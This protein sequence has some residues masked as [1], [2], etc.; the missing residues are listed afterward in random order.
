MHAVIDSG[1]T[2]KNVVV[3]EGIKKS[4]TTFD[5]GKTRT[6]TQKAKAKGY[7]LDAREIGAIGLIMNGMER[8]GRYEGNELMAFYSKL[9][10]FDI[11][12]F[13]TKKGK[14]HP[15]MS[16]SSC[17]AAMYCAYIMGKINLND[18]ETFSQI[19]N[20]GLPMDGVCS[21]AP[22]CLRRTIQTGVKNANGVYRN[23]T[24]LARI[25]IFEATYQAVCDFVAGKQRKKNYCGNGRAVWIAQTAKRV[26]GLE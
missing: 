10:D 4:V 22:L 6:V 1:V 18:V 2:L 17:L 11:V 25:E 23:N 24:A 3:V 8:I 13:A 26:A 16:N 7:N 12:S 9:K 15:I 5:D 20:S 14:N 19:C 21:F